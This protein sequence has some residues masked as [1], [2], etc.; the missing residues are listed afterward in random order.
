MSDV[1]WSK[2]SI[3]ARRHGADA[4]S[5]RSPIGRRAHGGLTALGSE[6]S[7]PDSI[8]LGAV[9]EREVVALMNGEKRG[10]SPF[11]E[12]GGEAVPGLGVGGALVSR[13]F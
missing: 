5:C 1:H 13:G 8:L 7:S 10:E 12:G 3:H 9:R 4:H 6:C 2:I 11:R